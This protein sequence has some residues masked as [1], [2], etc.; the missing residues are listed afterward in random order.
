MNII[1][2]SR[3][4]RYLV[5]VFIS[6]SELN[7]ARAGKPEDIDSTF[8]LSIEIGSGITTNYNSE[9]IGGNGIYYSPQLGVYWNPNHILSLGLESS[10]INIMRDERKGLATDF[11]RTDFKAAMSGIPIILTYRMNLSNLEITGGIGAAYVN[12]T[13]DAFSTEVST[14]FWYYSYYLSLGYNIPL[15]EKLDLG[16]EIMSN[17][18][19]RIEQNLAGINIK[20]SYDFVTW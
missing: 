12:S 5:I 8:S 11:G 14:N 19:P 17:S 20:I 4:L 3:I 16:I 9:R 15:S 7:L 1:D 13:I 18:I 10:F 2:K 6:I